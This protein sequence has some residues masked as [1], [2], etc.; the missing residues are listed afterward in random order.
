MAHADGCPPPADH[1][2]ELTDLFDLARRAPNDRAGREVSDRMWRVWLRAPDEAA[3]E[4]L[5]R[6]M[7]RR[8]SYDFV[9]AYEDF[10]RLAEYCPDYAEG[11]NQRAYIHYLREDYDK[12]LVDLDI[13]L[14]LSPTHVA[15]QS[16]RALT[17]MQLGR[18]PEARTQLLEALAN[19]PWLSERFL[20]AD[21]GPLAPVGE[22]L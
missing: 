10:D 13:A 11:F 7:R 16:G 9:G 18:I 15:A 2:S 12:A 14:G 6:G 4:V 17:L 21:G 19:N 1:A 3:Q 20:L 22:E 5:D 8:D